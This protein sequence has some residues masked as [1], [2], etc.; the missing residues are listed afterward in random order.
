MSLLYSPFSAPIDLSTSDGA[1]LYRVAAAIGTSDDDRLKVSRTNG[2][3][4]M[5]TLTEW[6][7]TYCWTK[8][9]HNVPTAL[10]MVLVQVPP[11]TN[12]SWKLKV[13]AT[14]SILLDSPSALTL[15]HVLFDAASVWSNFQFDKEN[16]LDILSVPTTLKISASND[17]AIYQDRIRRKIIGERLLNGL[18]KASVKTLML[19][20]RLFMWR[21]DEGMLMPDESDDSQAYSLT[22]LI[23]LPSSST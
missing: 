4:T 17:P 15:Q 2:K 22:R 10:E 23:L 11:S 12:Q 16:S 3:E 14:A 21:S 18:D 7:Q 6:S 1:K 8:G 5:D 20:E 19:K 13:N 9:V